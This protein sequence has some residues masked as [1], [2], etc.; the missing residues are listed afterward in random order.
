LPQIKLVPFDGS[1]ESFDIE[2]STSDEAQQQ[3]MDKVRK[4]D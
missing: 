3:M 1:I 4:S 2:N